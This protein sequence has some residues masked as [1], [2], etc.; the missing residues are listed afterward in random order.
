[1]RWIL[2]MHLLLTAM[3]VLGYVVDAAYARWRDAR[4]GG[5]ASSPAFHDSLVRVAALENQHRPGREGERVFVVASAP[6]DVDRADLPRPLESL[7]LVCPHGEAAVQTAQMLRDYG[8]F[9]VDIMPGAAAAQA[10]PRHAASRSPDR[11]PTLRLAPGCLE[12]RPFA[13]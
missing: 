2:K 10:E 9:Q 7:I 8:Y 1:M 13:M 5:F 3:L 12:W 6:R 4:S 11:L